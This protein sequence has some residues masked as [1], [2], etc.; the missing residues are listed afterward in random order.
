MRI[1]YLHRHADDSGVSGT[2]WV[3]EGVQFTDGKCALR[4]CVGDHRAT[5]VYE[6]I[7][8]I[9]FVHGH[10]GHTRI[11]WE[12]NIAGQTTHASPVPQHFPPHKGSNRLD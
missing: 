2:G 12:E 4:W 8:A 6:S 7:D 5:A 1:F 11:V 10:H 9:E 3:A